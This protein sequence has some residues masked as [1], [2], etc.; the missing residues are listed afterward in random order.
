[1]DECPDLMRLA[2]HKERMIWRWPQTVKGD[3]DEPR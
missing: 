1:M 3:D 2:Q